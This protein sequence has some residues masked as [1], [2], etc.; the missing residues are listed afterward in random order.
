[1]NKIRY[2]MDGIFEKRKKW[3]DWHIETSSN[4]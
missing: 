4:V 3:S 1:M 2:D